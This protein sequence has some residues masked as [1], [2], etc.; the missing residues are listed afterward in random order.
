MPPIT[1]DAALTLMALSSPCSLLAGFILVTAFLGVVYN[2]LDP[3]P[4]N[5]LKWFP[6]PKAGTY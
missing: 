5:D 2:L 3:S 4:F 1:L 6:Q